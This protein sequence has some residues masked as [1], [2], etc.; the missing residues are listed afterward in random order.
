MAFDTDREKVAHLLR[1]FGFGASEQELDFYSNGGVAKAIDRLVNF[2]QIPDDKNVE[3]EYFYIELG[4]AKVKAIRP[5]ETKIWFLSRMLTT[6]RPLE[7]RMTLFW[8]HH[9]ATSAEKVDSGEAMYKHIETLRTHAFGRFE[10]LLLSISRDPAMLYWLDN[11]DNVKGK[12]NE[13]FAR[14]IME[15]FTLGIGHYTEKDIQEA[16]RAFTGWRYGTERPN[17]RIVPTKTI[18]RKNSEFIFMPNLHD[19]GPKEILGNTGPFNGEDVC[20]ILSGQMQTSR[21]IVAKIWDWFVYPNPEPELVNRLATKWRKGG[22]NIRNLI[23]DIMESPEFFS[24]KAKDA[25]VKNPVDF[26]VASARQLGIGAGLADRVRTTE[27]TNGQQARRFFAPIAVVAQA[28]KAMGM[29]VLYPPDVAGW[30]IHN[31]WISTA[32][33][34]ERIKWAEKLFVGT[35]L[36]PR[37]GKAGRTVPAYQAYTLFDEGAD[38]RS[39]ANK[40]VSVFDARFDSKKIDQLTAAASAAM[41]GKPVSPQNAG[42]AAAAVSKLIF[43]SPEFQLI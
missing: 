24:E 30:N 42:P 10:E 3:I 6:Q 12:P 40:L 32:T 4:Q 14:E 34:I 11:G 31:S 27:A 23:R 21:Y 19:D 38:A 26:A 25:I 18:P 1:R 17:G 15:L 33:M 37:N 35:A 20:G 7:M 39:V 29:D 13:N 5:S 41:D 43:A 16:A 9:F 28:T 36:A 22:L 2:E 8:H